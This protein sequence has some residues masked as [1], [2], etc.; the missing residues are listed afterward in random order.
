MLR[1]SI[2]RYSIL[3]RPF[4][5]VNGLELLVPPLG[6]HSVTQIVHR[7]RVIALLCHVRQGHS[8]RRDDLEPRER[9]CGGCNVMR[10]DDSLWRG[11]AAALARSLPLRYHVTGEDWFAGAWLLRL[12]IDGA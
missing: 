8:L 5:R 3:L 1:K 12:S 7:V 4:H 11:V 2:P 9:K 6:C 10:H